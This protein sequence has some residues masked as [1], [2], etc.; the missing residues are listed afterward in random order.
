MVSVKTGAY[1]VAGVSGTIILTTHFHQFYF[2][3]AIA[4][5]VL[6]VSLIIAFNV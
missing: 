2:G 1:I 5:L 6:I 3:V 4:I